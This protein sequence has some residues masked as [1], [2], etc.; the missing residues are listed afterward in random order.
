MNDKKLKTNF[1]ITGKLTKYTRSQMIDKINMAGGIVKDR[2]TPD[3]DFLIVGDTGKFGETNKIQA[4]KRC[5]TTLISE[6]DFVELD[7]ETLKEYIN[8]LKTI[9]NIMDSYQ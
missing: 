6:N 3:I 8:G 4:A 1:V 7:I 2:I 9:T 5:G